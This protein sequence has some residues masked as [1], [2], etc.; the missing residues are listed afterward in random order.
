MIMK[1]QNKLPA[2]G[3]KRWLVFKAVC[4]PIAIVLLGSVT[5]ISQD[6]SPGP[7]PAGFLQIELGSVHIHADSLVKAWQDIGY[8]GIRTVLWL[9]EQFHFEGLQ[10]TFDKEKC[11]GTDLLQAFV[12]TYPDYTYTEDQQTGVVWLYPKKIG[13]AEILPHRI[14]VGRNANGISMLTRILGDL[15]RFESL[16]IRT[17]KLR[18]VTVRPTFDYPVDLPE[19][20][21][22]VREILNFCLVMNPA[23]TFYVSKSHRGFSAVTPV[24]LGYKSITDPSPAAIFFWKRTIG[25]TS[26]LAPKPREIIGALSSTGIQQKRAVRGYL[27]MNRSWESFGELFDQCKTPEE[28]IWTAI[29]ILDVMVRTGQTTDVLAIERIN[30]IFNEKPRSLIAPELKAVA[31]MELARVAKETTFLQQVAKQPLSASEVVNVKPDMIRILRYS[32]FVRT[33]LIELNPQWAGFSKADIEALGRMD[34]FSL[35]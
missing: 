24:N 28:I 2:E 25:P 29:G 14:K 11:N 6:A 1:I 35:P 9:E 23:E 18:G 32:E 27:E 8:S 17:G 34:I 5:A 16:E 20:T 26:G 30:K 33:K 13:Y 3:P 10:F 31:A 4:V 21:Y 7:K 22:S 12:A 15:S 19:G